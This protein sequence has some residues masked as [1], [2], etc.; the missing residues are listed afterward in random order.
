MHAALVPASKE[1]LVDFVGR[2]DDRWRN[3]NRNQ[4]NGVDQR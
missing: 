4:F 3:T 1:N 2:G